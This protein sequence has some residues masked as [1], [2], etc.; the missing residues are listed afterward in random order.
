MAYH[1][2]LE[3]F[4]GPLDL[5]L[6]LIGRAQLDIT[7][8]RLADITE[9]YME[10]MSDVQAMDMER[11][12]AFVAMAARLLEIKSAHLLPREG[13]GEEEEPTEDE[14]LLKRQ[15]ALYSQYRSI[16]EQLRQREQE[17]QLVFFRRPQEV[18]L[19]SDY[20]IVGVQ[21]DQLEQALRRLLSQRAQQVAEDESLARAQAIER[22]SFTIQQQIFHIR[23]RLAKVP[24]L[25]FEE[26]FE[27][28]ISRTEVVVTF[29][30]LLELMRLG[31][32]QVTQGETDGRITI[33]ARNAGPAEE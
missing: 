9:Q 3:Q 2:V 20:D 16:C 19:E 5:L 30:A 22:D 32:I 23:S 33:K 28:R 11:A 18:F 27:G 13:G 7:Q 15:L 17:N 24:S 29:I 12:S 4:E 21:V 8:I 6:H 25:T 14:Q 26:L 31:R 1:V 10:Y